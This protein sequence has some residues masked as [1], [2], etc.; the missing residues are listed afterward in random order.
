VRWAPR[1]DAALAAEDWLV[2]GTATALPWL[3]GGVSP[4]GFRTAATLLVLAWAVSLARDGFSAAV[5]SRWLAPALLLAAWAALQLV[6]LPDRVLGLVSPRAAAL[7]RMTFP[8]RAGVPPGPTGERIERLALATVAEIGA[9]PERPI[10]GPA[11]LPDPAGRWTGWR[12][13]SLLPEAGLERLHWYLALLAAFVVVRR[14]AADP[15]VAALY[16]AATFSGFVA[17]AVFGLVHAATSDGTL[18]WN[19]RTIEP[20][21]P[22][23]PYV[24]P[25]HFAG[26]ME[27]AVPWLAGA[28]VDAWS[29]ARLVGWTA[30]SAPLVVASTVL[31][32]AAGLATASKAA[33]VLLG[34]SLCAVWWLVGRT[35]RLGIVAFGI[36]AAVA[37][38]ALAVWFLPVGDR[39]EELLATTGADPRQVDR[40]VAALAA[41]P[42]LRDFS[43]AGCG[44]GA[45]GDVFP[46]YLPTGEY[47]R[48]EQLHNDYLEA[49]ISGGVVGAVL[50]AWLASAYARRALRRLSRARH[51][52]DATTVG[53]VVGLSALSVH[54]L[55]DFNHQIPANALLFVVLGALAVAGEDDAA[56]AP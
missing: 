12:P 10:A 46:A 5:R 36:A 6:P 17:L 35:R 4:W 28:A 37:I 3:F 52:H 34:A 21:R 45:F 33:L 51:E 27:L 32:L 50:L 25:A 1:A 41:L 47:M 16:R 44:Y 15:D 43:I 55:A 11:P 48:W 40:V 38:A 2:L 24:N 26:V 53:L 29:R 54:A 18:Y 39:V 7:D 31:C 8:D 22:F 13:I 49:A 42:M 30:S 19:W 9:V 20:S 56:G 14:R 23:G